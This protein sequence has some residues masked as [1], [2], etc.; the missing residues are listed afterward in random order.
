MASKKMY[1]MVVIFFFK[2]CFH[3]YQSVWTQ[4]S[5]VFSIFQLLD[6]DLF[7]PSVFLRCY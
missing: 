3:C 1:I 2:I 5:T 4:I 7:V 6:V